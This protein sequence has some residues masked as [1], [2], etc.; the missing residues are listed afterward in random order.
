VGDFYG[1]TLRP[2]SQK[3]VCERFLETFTTH[4][5]RG[6][7]K[8]TIATCIER[9]LDKSRASARD[10]Y[11]EFLEQ[12]GQDPNSQEYVKEAERAILRLKN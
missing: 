5:K 10:A 7:A 1:V 8:Y 11:Y 9:D 2:G 6:Y 4:P 3:R 12:Y